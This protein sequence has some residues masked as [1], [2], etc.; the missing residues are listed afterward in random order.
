MYMYVHTHSLPLASEEM[1]SKGVKQMEN[2]LE[3]LKNELKHHQKPTDKHDRFAEKIQEF[4]N[5]AE[6]RFKKLED[7][8]QFMEKKFEDLATF[9]CF[10]R[11]K[12]SMEEF[13]GDVV[14]FCKDF[15]VSAAT[16]I[17][18]LIL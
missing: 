10:D 4:L 6:A 2:N 15:D 9:Y 16:E 8:F 17:A 3:K 1:M 14:M 7:Q 11:K 5:K 18:H 12:I 13:F